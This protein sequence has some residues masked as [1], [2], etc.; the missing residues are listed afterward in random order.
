MFRLAS[1]IG[2]ACLALAACVMARNP[3]N[4]SQDD[5]SSEPNPRTDR[6]LLSRRLARVHGGHYHAQFSLN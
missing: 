4:P 5:N 2:V 3:A 6:N 1:L